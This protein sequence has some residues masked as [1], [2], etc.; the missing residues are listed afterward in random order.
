MGGTMDPDGQII[1]LTIKDGICQDCT[2]LAGKSNIV[3]ENGTRAQVQNGV[4]MH[5]LFS[6]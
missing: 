3:F 1:S 4:Y 2:V 6:E 5:H